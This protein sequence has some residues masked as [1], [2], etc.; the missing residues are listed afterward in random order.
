MSRIK[1]GVAQFWPV[2]VRQALPVIGI[3]LRGKDADVP[4]DL[5][6]VLAAAYED[7][8]YD[9]SVDYRREPE[10]PLSREDAA[11]AAKLLREQGLR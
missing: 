7:A 9:L 8:A 10:P 4:L 5:K 1:N 11:W 3:P 2:T 6:A